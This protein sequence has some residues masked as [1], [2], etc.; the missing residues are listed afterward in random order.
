MVLDIITFARFT[1]ILERLFDLAL[2]IGGFPYEFGAE[3]VKSDLK[4]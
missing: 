4:S 2:N 3:F 1:M